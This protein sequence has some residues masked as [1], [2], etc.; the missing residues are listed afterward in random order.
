MNFGTGMGGRRDPLVL[1]IAAA[2]LLLPS[3]ILGNLISH[4]SPQNFTWAAQFGDQFRAGILYPRWL[5][6]SF[7]GLGSSTFYF[8]PPIA[9]WV[10]ALLGVATFGALT[11]SY[12]L[13]L[14]SLVLLWASGLAMHA[15]LRPATASP[16]VA[17]YGALAYMAAPYHLVDHYYRGAF[18]EFA[19]YAVLPLVALTIRRI[20][21]GQRH[22]VVALAAAYAALPMAHLPTSLL[23]SLTAVPLYVLYRGWRLGAPMPALKFFAQCAL[24][25]ALGLGLAAI[26]LAPALA[27]QDWIPADTFWEGPYRVQNWFLLAPH[28]WPPPADMMWIIA[29]SAAAYAIAAVGVV[30]V[31]VRSEGPPGW[32]SEAMFWSLACLLCILLIAGALPWFW[33]LPFVAKVQFPWRLMIVVEFAAVTAFC[34]AWRAVLGRVAS[35]LPKVVLLALVPAIG[36]LLAG[37]HRRVEVSLAEADP[38]ADLKQ[39]LPAGFPQNPYGAYDE[40]GLE[41]LK[42]VPTIAC[43]PTPRTCR[44]TELPLGEL[45][46]EIEADAP[47]TVV[48]RRFAYPFWRV[49]PVLPLL[50]TDPLRLVSF[51][52]PTGRHDLRLEHA[53][54]LAEKAGWAISGLSLVLVLVGA[55]LAPHTSARSRRPVRAR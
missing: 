32:R 1:L 16:R 46:I 40:L 50:A 48:V 30:V 24:G 15:W 25:G 53:R 17:L 43:T 23:I 35:Y 13:S 45:A 22:G 34:L 26:Y 21:D 52:V 33:L 31:Q 37:V 3:L 8:Y 7:D 18:A 51:T 54:P 11:T 4:S 20:A 29:S 12:C 49:E 2:L 28:R 6:D 42:G 41:P 9:F 55:V 39:F 36:L 14:A 38:P 10:T 44:A 27:L 5:P 47:T 19:A